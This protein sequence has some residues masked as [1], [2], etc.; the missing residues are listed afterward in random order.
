VSPILT[1]A[2]VAFCCRVRP[3]TPRSFLSTERADPVERCL[4]CV[5]LGT[6]TPDGRGEAKK[7]VLLTLVD[8]FVSSASGLSTD[9]DETDGDA[10]TVIGR[11]GSISVSEA[12]NSGGETNRKPLPPPSPPPPASSSDG[13]KA[14]H[15]RSGTLN[16]RTFTRSRSPAPQS[17]GM[18]GIM[19]QP[20]LTSPT[21][22]LRPRGTGPAIFVLPGTLSLTLSSWMLPW[23]YQ[24][25]IDARH[26]AEG[27]ILMFALACASEK[28]RSSPSALLPSDDGLPIG[29]LLL[30]RGVHTM[31][32]MYTS[33]LY[34]V[35]FACFTYMVWNHSSFTRIP[36]LS[37]PTDPTAASSPST[38][39]LQEARLPRRGLI[40]TCPPISENRGYVWMTVPKNYRS[41]S[42]N[43]QRAFT[44]LG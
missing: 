5:Y 26:T 9:D 17:L 25:R 13:L 43:S 11:R 16:R 18:N 38:P 14:N 34:A 35:I 33:E 20:P 29:T 2:L 10:H 21:A 23:H 31:I 24:L 32:I 8:A 44:T 27:A 39:R 12:R 30:L 7:G 42:S 4:V 40:N 19:P 1:Q 3:S 22:F 36:P 41:I 6:F 15:G 37:S 28:L